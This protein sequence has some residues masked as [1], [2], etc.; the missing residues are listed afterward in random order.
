MSTL[1][2][3]KIIPTAGVPTGGGGGIIQVKSVTKTDVFSVTAS[4]GN[5]SD[6]TGLSVS[7]TPTTNTS[8]IL[9]YFQSNFSAAINQRG[10]F[11]LLR[12]STVINAAGADGNSTNESIFSS[13]CTR[14][15]NHESIPV[16]GVFLDSP[17]TASAVTYKLQVG[18]ENSAGTIYVNRTQ[19]GGTGTNQYLGVSNLLVQEVSA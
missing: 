12:G 6:I 7:I 10:S 5:F 3:N 1:K 2:V 19:A 15:N 18:A 8:K 14:D 17:T 13:L 4:D 16:A 9:I 11:R